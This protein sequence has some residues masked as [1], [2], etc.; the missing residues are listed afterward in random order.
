LKILL[1]SLIFLLPLRA[2]QQINYTNGQVNSTAIS[3]TAPN[4]PT[5]LNT[6]T[7][8]ATQS[9]AITGTGGIIIT[10]NGTLMLANNSNSY[11][12]G[13]TMNSG[14]LILTGGNLGSSLGGLTVNGGTVDLF[15]NTITTGALSGTGGTILNNKNTS[16]ILFIGTGN[17]SGTYSG[18]LADHSVGTG[19]LSLIKMG[20]GTQVLAGINTYTGPTFAKEGTLNISG[21]VNSSNFTVGNGA[22]TPTLAGT[23][24]I[25][26]QL[27]TTFSGSF[28]PHIAPGATLGAVGTLH[29]GN[30]GFTIG[31]GTNFDYDLNTDP[32]AGGASNDLISMT[33]GTLTFSGTTTFN[34]DVMSRLSTSANYT[35][36]SGA[37]T[38][39]GFNA[40]HFTTTGLDSG[41][42]ATYSLVG[43]TLVVSFTGTTTSPAVAYFNGNT[44]GDLNTASNFYTSASGTTV[45]ASAVGSSTDVILTA[46]SG[47][48]SLHTPSLNSGNLTINS[49]TLTGTGNPFSSAIS[50][51]GTSSLTIKAAGL[52]AQSGAVNDSIN[53]PIV[54]G[55]SQ[56]WTVNDTS[57]PLFSILTVGGTVSGAGKILTK[58]GAGTLRLNGNNI[59][60]GGTTVVSGTLIPGSSTTVTGSMI[61]SGPFGTGLLT[62]GNGTGLSTSFVSG[63]ITLANSLSLSGTVTL[64]SSG[65]SLT[66]DGSGLLTPATIA[67]TGTTTLIIHGLLSVNDSITGNSPLTIT[68]GMVAISSTTTS[69][70]STTLSS[71]GSA[72]ISNGQSLG[73]GNITLAFG[74]LGYSG[75]SSGTLAQNITVIGG[76]I[77]NSSG[78]VLTLNGTITIA[79]PG[80][81]TLSI[82]GGRDVINGPILG[83]SA[84]SDTN[85]SGN[86]T[87]GLNNS[88]TYSGLTSISGTSTVLTGVNN[89]LPSST[90]IRFGVST[91][92]AGSVNTL[93]LLGTSQTIS[94]IIEVGPDVNQIISSNGSASTPAIGSTA[95]SATGVLTLNITGTTATSYGGLLGDS[96]GSRAANNFALTKSGTGVLALTRG[97]GNLYTGGT[98]ITTGTLVVSNT[99]GS[100]TGTGTLTLN[101]GATLAGAGAINSSSNT[102]S[103]V[104]QAG[105]G[106]TSTTGSMTLTATGTTSF[107]NANLVFN[108]SSTSL[109]QST[110]LD[111]GSTPS[112]LFSNTTLTLDLV[113]AG[114]IP[115]TTQY[116]LLT[117]SLTG[118]GAGGSVFG[119][120]TVD[121]SGVISGLTV[122]FN[123]SSGNP[124]SYYSPSYLKLVSNGSGYNIDI[125]VVPEPET[126]ALIIGGMT[127]IAL[128]QWRRT[129]S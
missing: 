57:N 10:G 110:T 7:G 91:D 22:L 104:V 123:D 62:L 61:T 73:S 38:T 122:V 115:N 16:A 29:L 53:V 108:L 32:T 93:D 76:G 95:S 117:S 24:M 3:T 92:P 19:V 82:T 121:G 118:S 83:S 42:T 67:L 25:N 39:S 52:T 60:D 81:T 2:Q 56:T 65:A 85:F 36:I 69:A 40:T 17:T 87:I 106:G 72:F 34:F 89:A 20:S 11:S 48:S 21:T 101:S 15:G 47:G 44:S 13:T 33:G 26:S 30:L 37:S 127:L 23:G 78:N 90:T 12:G 86:S 88:N 74:S 4:D 64:E 71:G 80:G 31:N 55:N 45:I 97:A 105:A 51:S 98:L 77:S 28:A 100:A 116:T 96:N 111:V 107:S 6:A 128:C 119:G 120:I 58:A 9:G 129:R 43:T 113:G 1:P 8:T 75:T 112:V 99:S 59:Y 114:I 66:L 27:S 94:G 103:G 35:L 63:A 46:N 109:G 70:F 41:L 68:A 79:N 54:L 5:T 124:T 49:L 126:W 102:I 18:V 50:L 84:G 125:E 14:V